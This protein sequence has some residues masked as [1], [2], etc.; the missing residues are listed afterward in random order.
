MTEFEKW[1]ESK[2]LIPGTVISKDFVKE[3]AKNAWDARG[4]MDAKIC[5]EL[6]PPLSSDASPGAFAKAIEA[7]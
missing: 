3:I 2:N 1:F 6:D 7:A 4:E 5:R